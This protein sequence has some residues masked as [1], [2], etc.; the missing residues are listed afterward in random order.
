MLAQ[1]ESLTFSF[2][3]LKRKNQNRIE[4]ISSLVKKVGCSGEVET[5][6][7]TTE[8]QDVTNDSSSEGEQ[9]N[10]QAQANL[11]FRSENID[12][13]PNVRFPVPSE[14]H[15][16]EK[17]RIKAETAIETIRGI[18]VQDDI[19]IEDFIKTVKKAKT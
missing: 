10:R 17:G 6:K 4:E 19:G 12:A 16:D 14:S 15:I 7:E 13:E 5:D 3:T 1:I 18:N 9:E 11:R 8:R 2:K